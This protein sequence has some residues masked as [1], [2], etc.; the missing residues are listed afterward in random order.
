M[1]SRTCVC[2]SQYHWKWII[3]VP[4][5]QLS[6]SALPGNDLKLYAIYYRSPRPCQFWSHAINFSRGKS[7][8]TKRIWMMIMFCTAVWTLTLHCSA[9]YLLPQMCIVCN[10]LLRCTQYNLCVATLL[11]SL[12]QCKAKHP[13]RFVLTLSIYMEQ[14]QQLR[15]A[16]FLSKQHCTDNCEALSHLSSS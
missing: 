10:L 9:G 14:L 1:Y 4:W 3:G 7:S 13:A 16:L 2:R 15:S 11:F 5:R 6:L 8:L 12:L